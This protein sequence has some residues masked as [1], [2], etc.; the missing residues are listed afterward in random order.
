MILN[1]RFSVHEPA[2]VEA[3]LFPCDTPFTNE[4]IVLGNATVTSPAIA[5][6]LWKFLSLKMTVGMISCPRDTSSSSRCRADLI[7]QDHA[8]SQFLDPALSNLRLFG[9]GVQG[10][11]SLEK[12]RAKFRFRMDG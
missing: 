8:R 5:C 10:H 12:L 7:L 9:V 11:Q 3:Q 2:A 4:S 6:L 1:I